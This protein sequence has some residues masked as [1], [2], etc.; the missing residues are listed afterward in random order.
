MRTAILVTLSVQI[1]EF[2]GKPDKRI[3]GQCQ[4]NVIAALGMACIVGNGEKQ[5]SNHGPT[6]APSIQRS[7]VGG[8]D[9]RQ[10]T[11]HGDQVE[12]AEMDE[13]GVAEL[14]RQRAEDGCRSAHRLSTE[15][16]RPQQHIHP[17]TGPIE[18]ANGEPLHG[19]I[20]KFR[21]GEEEQQVRRIKEAGLNI[22]DEGSAAIEVR[23]P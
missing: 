21:I 22:A 17:Q 23:V 11:E 16:H 5:R 10:P 6:H 14:E 20:G 2:D 9:P 7:K 15:T 13:E 8:K 3:D 1:D 18:M 19:L 4:A 12:I